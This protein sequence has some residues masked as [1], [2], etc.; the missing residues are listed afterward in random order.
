VFSGRSAAVLGSSN[1]ST[2]KTRELYQ[3]SPALKLAAAED[4]RT[5][6]NTYDAALYGSQDGWYLF[7]VRSARA[8]R[9]VFGGVRP[10]SGAETQAE[11]VAFG[12]SDPLERAD[13]VA[14]EDGR[15][16][17]NTYGQPCPRVSKLQ[18]APLGTDTAIYL[19]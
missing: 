14:A 15:T 2:P 12:K 16:P 3:I 8:A 19:A 11:P 10:S 7:S 1:D 18:P 13:V 6:L 5:P 4:G 9:A 17:P